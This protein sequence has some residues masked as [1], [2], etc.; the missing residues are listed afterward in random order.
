MEELKAISDMIVA[1]APG[2]ELGLGIAGLFLGVVLTA[3]GVYGLL[4]F[5]KSP[6]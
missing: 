6:R 4:R 2:G 1:T 5:P 3:V